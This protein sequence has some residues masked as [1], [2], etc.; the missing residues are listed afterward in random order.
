MA[1]LARVVQFRKRAFSS[2]FTILRWD[3]ILNFCC[4]LCFNWILFILVQVER[5]KVRT[6]IFRK[7]ELSPTIRSEVIVVWK[8]VKVTLFLIAISSKV[9][10]SKWAYIYRS[11]GNLLSYNIS[12]SLVS[13]C[14]GSLVTAWW[15]EPIIQTSPINK[16]TFDA[17]SAS[18]F[19]K[20][21]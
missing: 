4:K 9:S 10:K 19:L 18:M 7:N 12:K 2:I 5:K 16:S 15:R 3:T 11:F 6:F 21:K 1:A 17:L 14:S 20:V 8:Q 13:A